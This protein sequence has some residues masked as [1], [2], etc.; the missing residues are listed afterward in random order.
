[1]LL[2][3][4]FFRAVVCQYAACTAEQFIG[5]LGDFLFTPVKLWILNH[6]HDLLLKP[7]V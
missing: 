1:M 3:D 4:F 6:V 2:G 5:L 7:V